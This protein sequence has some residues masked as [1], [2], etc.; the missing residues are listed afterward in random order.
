MRTRLT[1]EIEADPT[2]PLRLMANRHH[3]TLCKVSWHFD[4]VDADRECFSLARVVR[5]RISEEIND[6]LRAIRKGRP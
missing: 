2:S 5:N 6:P 3:V 4:S 1:F